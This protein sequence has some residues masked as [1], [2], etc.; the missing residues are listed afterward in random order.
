NKPVWATFNTATGALTGTPLK[1]H[2]GSSND[3]VISVS[4]GELSAALPAFNLQVVNVN[5]APSALDDSFTLPFSLD[6][7]YQLHVLAN[8]TDPDDDTLTITFATASIGAVTVVDNQL[9]VSAPDNFN[10]LVSLSY[11]I[12]DG[13]FNASAKVTLQIDGANPDAPVITVP[14]DLTVNATGLFTKVDVGVAVALDRN[15]NRLAVQLDKNT[16]VFSPG[17]HQ[18]YWSATDADGISSTTTQLL[19]VLPLVSLSKSQTVVNHSTV[20]VDVILNGPSPTY[21]VD[22][23]YSISGSAGEGDHDLVAGT[24]SVSSGLRGTIS[25]NV[26][27]DLITDTSKELVITLDNGPNLTANAST[28]V[29]ITDTNLPPQVSLSLQQQ[30]VATSLVTPTGGPVTVTA[31]VLDANEADS[32]TFAWQAPSVGDVT[33]DTPEITLQA[34]GLTGT[35]SVTVSVTDSAGATVQESIYFRVITALPVLDMLAD[36]DGDGLADALEGTGDSDGNGI[37]NYLDNMPSANILPQRGNSS[38]A[39]LVECDPGVRCGLGLFARNGNSGGAQ[40]LDNELGTLDN[41]AADPSFEPVGGIFDFAIND[42]P[43]PGQ[44]VQVILPQRN[45]VP[46]GAV[47]RKFQRGNWISFVSDANNALHSAAGNPGYCPP[48][49]AAAWQPGLTAGHWCVKL[50]IEDGGPNDDDGLVNAAVVDPGGVSM[51]RSDNSKPVAN[52]DSYNQQWNQ[53]HQLMVLDN[54]TDADGDSL[55]ISQVYAVFGV[56]TISEDGLSLQ[57]TPA[58]DFIG[59]DTLSYTINDGNNGNASA[60]VNLTLYY[61]N[62]PTLSNSNVST[63]DRTAIDINVL[64]NASDADADTLTVTSATAQTGNVSI[65]ADQTLRYTPQ[66]GF[67]GTD[68]ISVTI[69]DGRGGLASATVSVT[70]QAV[71]VVTPP[72][73][74]KSSG[75]SFGHWLLAMLTLMLLCRRKYQ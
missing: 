33:A 72:A 39:Y 47:Y 57:Y 59:T 69:S 26:F 40:I 70:V 49:G 41:L 46:E 9:R 2:V 18:L 43:T 75:G 1:E 24:V 29:T 64:A 5:E 6:A 22:I 51:Q 30:G 23:A 17:E 36:T 74:E 54:D 11:S 13:E 73:E 19:R 4:D 50:T 31:T 3:I 56:A 38:G 63:D 25:F 48:P 21:P 71:P 14:D 16:L 8:D 65:S 55:T 15:G 42:L 66:T 62:A 27:A 28:T 58:Q 12:T 35:H 37:P 34:T 20:S 44:S 61:N 32:H 45:V 53:T 60:N 68:V 10:G 7:V 52:N 67:N